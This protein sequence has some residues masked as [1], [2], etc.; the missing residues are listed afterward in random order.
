MKKLK[1]ITLLL[2]LIPLCARSQYFLTG[3]DPAVL[4]WHQIVTPDFQLIY[5]AEF[6]DKAKIMAG[7]FQKVYQIGSS[8]LRH[9][10][11][12]IS[13]IF[14]TRTVRSNGLVGYAPKRMEIYTTPNQDIPAQDWLR[15][16]VLH[17]F[18]H[19]VQVDKIS[20]QVPKI[21]KALLGEQGVALVTG[22]YLPFWFLEGDAVI[23]ETTLSNAG[24]GRDPSFLSEQRA[25]LVEKGVFSFDKAYNGSFRDYVPDHYKLGYT[26]TGELR[27]KYGID[28]WN[29]VI[30]RLAQKPFSLQP[31]KRSLILQTG[32]NQEKLYK[33]VFDSLRTI[34]IKQDNLCKPENFSVITKQTPCFTSYRY[35]HI[36]NSGNIVSLKSGYDQVPRFVLIEPSGKESIL[37]TP[38]EIFDESVGYRNHLV[39]WSENV[40]DLRW[41]HSGR[42]FIRIYDIE[43]REMKTIV[44]DYKC[45][46]PAIS[47]DEHNVAV[48][49]AD[50]SNQYFLSVYST[51]NGTLVRRY[52]TPGNNYLFSP[53]WNDNTSLFV[54]LLT[55]DGK[56]LSLIDPYSGQTKQLVH[57]DLGEI[58]QLCWTGD[59]LYFISSYAA[60]NELYSIQPE[61]GDIRREVSARFG[62]GYPAVSSDGRF[63]V[64]SDYTAN[65]FRLIE[66]EPTALRRE[67]L[68]QI[69]KGI[70]PLAEK[71]ASQEQG[72][73]DFDSPDSVQYRSVPF[74]KAADLFHFHSW[75]PFSFEMDSR[76]LKPGI[77]FASQ[78]KLGTSVTTMGYKWNNTESSGK[79]YLRYEY[80]GFY[81]VITFEAESGKRSSYYSLITTVKDQL[82]NIVKRDTT[83]KRFFWNQSDF[84]LDLRAPLNLTNGKYFRLLQPEIKYNFTKY[85]HRQSTPERF[86]NGTLQSLI[87]R[88][89]YHQVMR[90]SYRDLQ[91]D[92]GWIADISY[93]R[94][95][96]GDLELGKLFAA[97][98]KCYWP[99]FAS[100]HGFSTSFGYQE[101]KQ[102][103]YNF[104]D[105]IDIPTG[106]PHP[107]SSKM[108]VVSARYSMPLFYP[109]LN[110][111]K[112]VYIRRIS[113]SLFYDYARAL[114]KR[115]E[116][117]TLTGTSLFPMTSMGMEINADSNFVRL[118]APA[119]FGFRIS[120]M[121]D[122]QAIYPNEPKLNFEFLFSV[123]FTSF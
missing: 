24:R 21:V 16:L 10:P 100:T 65:G 14:H 13:V 78:N 120:Y 8:T 39:V 40:P 64:L 19:V 119:R 7:Y 104:S 9:K 118:Y 37:Y 77:S 50:F 108:A 20:S 12:K 67:P 89:Y 22:L 82:G 43:S 80:T 75:A 11:R 70:Y 1:G 112:F 81:P 42:S 27:A 117:N 56:R 87:G 29:N 76:E 102:G 63:L 106:W 92:W 121:P 101:R 83:V 17:E 103:E 105:V 113:S 26:L 79:Y 72:R 90:K 41:G 15:H 66:M 2:I 110:A 46:A 49:E 25:Q 69:T 123:D 73:V 5:P 96:A 4:R 30:D 47:P 93:R 33:M 115:Y 95:P 55:G 44:P 58:R 57:Q 107:N 31:V 91:P 60:K 97:R 111:G 28:L 52:Q 71:L 48:V 18:R 94:S 34:W 3:E 88:I 74:K 35:N 54:I 32:M 86:A 38:G 23:T 109:D 36:L 122:I 61:R 116:N 99:G 84:S 98:M 114:M 62:V 85:G 51:A 68:Q 6:E 53:V 45:F 59:R